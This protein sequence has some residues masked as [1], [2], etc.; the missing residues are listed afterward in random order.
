MLIELVN[1]TLAL[2]TIVSQVGMVVLA[3]YFLMYRKKKN[4]VVAFLGRHGMLLAFLVVLFSVLGSLFYSRIAGFAPCDLCWYQRI[5]MYPQLILL[6]MALLKK[7]FGTTQGGD[8]H[9]IDYALVLCTIGFWVSVYQNYMYYFNQGLNAQCLLS[10]MQL[11]C[12]KRYVFEF[13]Y[14]TI[15]VMSLTAFVLTMVFL[16]LFKF[17]HKF[18]N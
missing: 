15:P 8:Y 4:P 17:H 1:K 12:I 3:G 16:L 6:G 7:P 2:G 14:V 11:S 18:H 5:F 9:I 13:G 10:G